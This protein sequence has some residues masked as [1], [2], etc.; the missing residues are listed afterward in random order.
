MRK[1]SI[2]LNVRLNEKEAKKLHEL[3][4]DSGLT[5]SAVLRNLVMGCEIKPR[6]P[7]AYR[8]MAREMAAIGN[9]VNQLAR[10]ANRAGT[11]TP[12]QLSGLR[13]E[14]DELRRVL[15]EV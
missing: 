12:A 4:R 13:Q 10:A 2:K 3:A 9:N 1:R 15:R 8:E 14:L 11:A 6:R 5:Q 7:E